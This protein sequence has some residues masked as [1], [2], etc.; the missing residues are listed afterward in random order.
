HR[1]AMMYFLW[2][3]LG[4]GLFLAGVILAYFSNGGSFNI[5]DLSKVHEDSAFW[6]CFLILI[7]WLIKMAI[8]GFHVWLPYVDGEHST[9]VAAISTTIVGLGNY[10]IVRLLVNNLFNIFQIFS[11][12]LMIWALITMVYGAFLTLSQDDV[13]RLYACS[14]ISQNAYSILGIGSCTFLG[15][16]GGLFYF[17]S[18]M[19]GKCILFSIAGIIVYLT[20]IRDMNKLSGLARIAP[21]TAI[22]AILG[23]MILSAIPPLSGFQ[24]EWIM[25][26]GIF[27]KGLEIGYLVGLIGI[28][29]TFL[30]LVYTF[31]PIKRI[32]FGQVSVEISLKKN[33]VHEPLLMVIPLYV[34]SVISLIFGL[35]PDLIMKLLKDAVF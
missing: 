23:S 14:T 16:S 27:E 22:L 2:N 34:L 18:H 29:A 3:H 12:P 19:I 6:V 1:I 7:G 25:F 24:A 11:L 30:T 8:F 33:P 5:V 17:I 31:W 4:A 26:A 20:E 28:F 35:Y 13:K 21:S 10:V 9:S 32:F 15:I